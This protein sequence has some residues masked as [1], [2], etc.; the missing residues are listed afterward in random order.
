MRIRNKLLFDSNI[1]LKKEYQW[2]YFHS[3]CVSVHLDLF[4][5]VVVNSLKVHELV[6]LEK[7]KT[8]TKIKVY[9]NSSPTKKRQRDDSQ[10]NPLQNNNI[11][12]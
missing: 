10:K 11:Q 8:V 9:S 6:T 1:I 4:R 5:V 3:E 2:S 7:S 12:R